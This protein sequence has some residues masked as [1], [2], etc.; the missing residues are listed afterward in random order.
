MALACA[1]LVVLVGLLLFQVKPDSARGRLLIWRITCEAIAN[2]PMSGCGLGGFPAAFGGAQEAWFSSKPR[3]AWQKRVAGS[4]EYAFCD[5]LQGMAELGIPCALAI[6]TGVTI[7]MAFGVRRGRTGVVGALLSLLVFALSSY[8]LQLPTFKVVSVLLLL[9]CLSDGRRWQWAVL[10]LALALWGGLR[11]DDDRRQEQACR[12]WAVCRTLYRTGSY[13]EA[14]R[15]YRR[16]LPLLCDRPDFLFEYGHAM[17]RL[18]RHAEAIL[19]L[20]Q[21]SHYSNDP[22]ILNVMAQDEQSL[23]HYEAA[24][25]LL[26][27]S[28]HLQPTRLYPYYLLARL[29]ALPSYSHPDRYRWARDIVLHSTPKVESTAVKQMREQLRQMDEEDITE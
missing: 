21:A 28:T 20:N 16:L 17:H 14:C 22:M 6:M 4:P 3:P 23:G 25:R 29:Y 26:L 7:C 11:L 2:R 1:G 5:Y 24:E 18:D 12:E 9:A 8:P 15:D 13:A 10:A 27:R 19:I